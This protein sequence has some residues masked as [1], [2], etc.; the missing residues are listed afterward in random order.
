M[1]ADKVVLSIIEREGLKDGD[2]SRAMGR[3]PRYLDAIRYRHVMP[4]ADTMATVCDVVGYDLIVRSREDGF[5][6]TVDPSM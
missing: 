3:T 2:V 5:E 4:K 1:R 6:I